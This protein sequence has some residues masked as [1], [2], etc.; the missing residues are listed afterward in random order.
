MMDKRKM[1]GTWANRWIFILAATGSAVGLGNIWK[2][3]YIAGEN[4]GGAFVLVYLVCIAVIGIPIMMAET[5]IGRRG[6]QSPVNTMRDLTIEAGMGKAWVGIGWMGVIAGLL[7]LSFYS[8]IAGWSLKY[9]FMMASGDFANATADTVNA[10]FETLQANK[11]DLIQWHSI[12]MLMTLLVVTAGVTK[13]LGNAVRILMPIL[14]VLLLV[15]LGYGIKEGNFSEG[16]NFLFDFDFGKLSRDGVLTALGHAFFTLSLGMGAIMAYGAYMPDDAPI[17][18][19]IL[20]VAALDTLVAIVAGLA[21][22]PIVFAHQGIEPSAGP[23]LLFV[24]LPL[25]FGNM[26]GGLYFGTAFFI[27]VSL[28]AWSS[29]ISL[30]E[31]GVAWLV[32]TKKCN[33]LVANMILGGIAWFVGLGTV[34]S[35]NDW[36][37][38]DY[39]IMGVTVFDFIDKLT[40]NVM[41]PLGGMFIAI[42]AGWCMHKTHVRKE[43]S[44]ESQDVF[45]IWHVLIRWV[46]PV[47]VGLVFIDLIW[48]LMTA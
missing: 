7:I 13:G 44:H 24:S 27:L 43:L 48:K 36:S 26:A 32:E 38:P 33:R 20:I 17:G 16:F 3:P 10:H 18:K 15:L 45:E 35:F 23:G 42:F 47:L 22:F 5:M 21:I 34:F 2:F 40:A 8:V 25:A 9:I 12:F 41:L 11:S 29:A 1:H 14:F 30:I 28:A 31:P 6:R 4:G 46:S 39:H 19:T 37:G